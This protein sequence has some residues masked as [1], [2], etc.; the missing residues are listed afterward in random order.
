MAV[1]VGVSV[2]LV[3]LEWSVADFVQSEVRGLP[4]GVAGRTY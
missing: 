4:L 2:T 3:Y 1:W